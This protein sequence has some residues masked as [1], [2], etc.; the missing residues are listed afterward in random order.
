MAILTCKDLLIR[1]ENTTVIRG[2]SFAVHEGDYLCIVGDNGAG[3][4]TLLKCILGLKSLQEGSVT[5]DPA[6]I[7][8][9]SAPLATKDVPAAS[10]V[11]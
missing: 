9:V 3:K 5:F 2:L 10:M 8:N 7:L 11:L 4:S 1:Y 6:L